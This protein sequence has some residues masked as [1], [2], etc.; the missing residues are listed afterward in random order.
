KRYSRSHIKN[1][2]LDSNYGM[3]ASHLARPALLCRAAQ[4][5]F[6]FGWNKPRA[7]FACIGRS[8]RTASSCREKNMRR[9]RSLWR[10]QS[11]RGRRHGAIHLGPESVRL[12]IEC[13]EERAL[14]SVE[15]VISSMPAAG[16][17]VTTPPA[18][19]TINFSRRYAPESVQAT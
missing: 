13:L 17:V 8:V 11:I 10:P 1:N 2:G 7:D 9:I 14:L 16:S 3:S 15:S 12:R 4:G 19:F 6:H 5:F 18:E